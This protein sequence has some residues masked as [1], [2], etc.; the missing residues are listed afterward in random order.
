MEVLDDDLA[1]DHVDDVGVVP[2]TLDGDL[3]ATHHEAADRAGDAVERQPVAADERTAVVV[4]ATVAVDEAG[5]AARVGPLEVA[6][7]V[8]VDRDHRAGVVAEVVVEDHRLGPADEDRGGGVA[9]AAR[10][11]RRRGAGGI[12]LDPAVGHAEIALVGFDDVEPVEGSLDRTRAAAKGD[13]GIVD[14]RLGAGVEHDAGPVAGGADVGLVAIRVERAA[15][16]VAAV[17]EAREHDPLGGRALRDELRGA[18]L[19]F[20]PRAPEFH[21]DAGVDREAAAPTGFHVGSIDAEIPPRATVDEEVFLEHVDDVGAREPG[22]YVEFVERLSEIRADLHEQAVDRVLVGRVAVGANLHQPVA[23]DLGAHAAVRVLE[24]VGVGGDRGAGA[25]G[26]GVEGD[27]GPRA[28]ELDRGERLERRVDEHLTAA[29]ADR[30]IGD[31]VDEGLLGRG[32]G[33]LPQH[34]ATPLAAGDDRPHLV[35][36]SADEVV[37]VGAEDHVAI[38]GAEH[39]DG[40]PAAIDQLRRTADVD[41]RSPQLDHGPLVDH[42]GHTLRYVEGLAVRQRLATEVGAN[43]IG[44]VRGVADDTNDLG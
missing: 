7:R 10:A 15:G 32:V 44:S 39:L 16:P 12:A 21:D 33:I 23:A 31:R 2:D 3:L 34:E 26:D 18:P 43:E 1:L 24:A 42:E 28:F 37:V 20:D 4:V 22:R 9:T 6:E 14:A 27:R 38:G 25:V 5:A 13:I 19:E 36:V 11:A 40:G 30:R 35:G 29:V 17:A 8:G 41:D